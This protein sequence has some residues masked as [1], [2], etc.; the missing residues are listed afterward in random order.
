MRRVKIEYLNSN[1]G[2]GHDEDI[3]QRLKQAFEAA[4]VTARI[5]CARSGSEVVKLAQRA[6]RS[7]A[8]IIVAGGGDGTVSSIAAALV[9]TDKALGVLPFGTMN[10]FGKDLGIPLSSTVRSKRS[11][12]AIRVES[13]WA[14][15]TDTPY[16]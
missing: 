15:S 1:S 4:G 16:K 5:N 11:W 14:K 10:H 8:E 2:P 3:E 6:A 7:D 12:P 13:I 9:N